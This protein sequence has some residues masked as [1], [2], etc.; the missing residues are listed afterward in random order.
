M[1]EGE[2]NIKD[3]TKDEL[4][5]LLE[6]ALMSIKNESDANYIDPLILQEEYEEMQREDRFY[7]LLTDE[8]KERWEVIRRL[9]TSRDFFK[10]S[11][12]LY[13]LEMESEFLDSY[14]E[15]TGL[16]TDG[17]R[18][19]LKA[20]EAKYI[21]I[22]ARYPFGRALLDNFTIEKYLSLFNDIEE[23][24]PKDIR[25]KGEFEKKSEAEI[26][27]DLIEYGA[28]LKAV[29]RKL[30]ALDPKL[31]DDLHLKDVTKTDSYYRAIIKT[32][33]EDGIISEIGENKYKFRSSKNFSVRDLAHFINSLYSFGFL[34]FDITNEQGITISENTFER[35]Y[36]KGYANET[37]FMPKDYE[38]YR[39]LVI[40]NL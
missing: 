7:N 14:F 35:K 22:I 21:E 17:I 26:K 39:K 20:T 32:L 4:N 1:I 2:K 15:N 38:R 8:E 34:K 25:I 6:M 36:S 5:G 31:P 19:Y 12:Y 16:D 13:H 33:L 37:D 9:F 30:S 40:S 27:E 29:I 23:F 3:L 10:Q 28:K 18:A 11:Q 24:R